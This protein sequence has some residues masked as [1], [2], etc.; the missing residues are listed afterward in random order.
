MLA[1][2]YTPTST[3]HAVTTVLCYIYHHCSANLY[4]PIRSELRIEKQRLSPRYA[5]ANRE[6]GFLAQAL[7]YANL[8]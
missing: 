3:P 5:A 8:E 6:P 2:S 1:Q 7:A 4:M